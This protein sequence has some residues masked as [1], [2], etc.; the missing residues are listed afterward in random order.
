VGNDDRIHIFFLTNEHSSSYHHDSG[1]TDG[2]GGDVGS[3]IENYN[4]DYHDP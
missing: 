4:H 2:A 3:T 1:T